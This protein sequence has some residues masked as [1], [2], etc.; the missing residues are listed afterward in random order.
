MQT[1]PQQGARGSW[2]ASAVGD[3]QWGVRR[4]GTF[5]KTTADGGGGSAYIYIQY[6]S[7]LITG[8]SDFSGYF[9]LP[10]QNSNK[11]SLTPTSLLLHCARSHG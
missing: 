2:V 10:A 4:S 1:H 8:P 6:T 9:P 5:A 3:G 7:L 11:T